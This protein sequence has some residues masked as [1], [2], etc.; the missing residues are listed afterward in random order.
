MAGYRDSQAKPDPE[1]ERLAREGRAARSHA[2]DAAAGDAQASGDRH[3]R[4]ALAAVHGAP[5]GLVVKLAAGA[6]L[7]SALVM[8]LLHE[9]VP[10][11]IGIATLALGIILAIASG[12]MSPRANDAALE[13]E[14]SW[15][16]AL[17]FALEGYFEVLSAKPRSTGGVRAHITWRGE[18]AKVD[19]QLL[20][21]A[22]AAADPAARLEH[23]DTSGAVFGSGPI[24]GETGGRI[25]RVP[26]LRNHRYPEYVH[27]LVEKVLV[28]LA[29]SHPIESVRLEPT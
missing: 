13:A 16:R 24:R 12:V 2:I 1:L 22:F 10:A 3:L 9:S 23:A 15:Y 14:R 26:V 21:D 5:A 20:A 8:I 7:M 27:T 4:E 6:C 11:P 28:P 18:L 19:E 29:R 17:P 25:N